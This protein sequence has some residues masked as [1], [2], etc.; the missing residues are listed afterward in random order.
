VKLASIERSLTDI[1]AGR[2]FD[3]TIGELERGRRRS[4]PKR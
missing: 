1:A 3:L 4:A 2:V